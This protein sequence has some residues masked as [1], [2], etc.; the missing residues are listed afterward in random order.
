MT[1]KSE[2]PSYELGNTL[3]S[4]CQMRKCIAGCQTSDIAFPQDTLSLKEKGTILIILVC[5]LT[6][7][8]CAAFVSTSAT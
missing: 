1:P 3:I 8:G 6:D 7:L 4:I 5:P 2:Q